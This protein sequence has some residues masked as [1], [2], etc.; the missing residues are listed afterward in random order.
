MA[1]TLSDIVMRRTGIGTLGNP[2]DEVLQRVA[3]LAARELNWDAGKIKQE[4]S[5]TTN[6]L[7]L[8]EA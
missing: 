6:L 8:P 3:A 7:K 2:G 4:I 1:R 5:V